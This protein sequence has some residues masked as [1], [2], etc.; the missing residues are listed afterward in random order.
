M[1]KKIGNLREVREKKETDLEW[2]PKN[3]EFFLGD[4]R[5]AALLPTYFDRKKNCNFFAN[6]MRQE[7]LMYS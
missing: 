2:K 4:L 5:Y 3:L 6:P 1:R 7:N